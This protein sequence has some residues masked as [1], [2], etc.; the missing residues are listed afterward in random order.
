MSPRSDAKV[1]AVTA[2]YKQVSKNDSSSV[3]KTDRIRNSMSLSKE[4]YFETSY[5]S[6]QG[7]ATSKGSRKSVASKTK[8]ITSNKRCL[9]ELV[10]YNNTH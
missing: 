6:T 7:A 9:S 4:D 2:Y 10:D 3:T 8:R 5:Q 1:N